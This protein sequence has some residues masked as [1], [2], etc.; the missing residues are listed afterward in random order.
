MAQTQS[1]AEELGHPFER[2][3][4]GALILLRIRWRM[5]QT[6]STETLQFAQERA[7]RAEELYAIYTSVGGKRPRKESLIE[8][9]AKL[10]EDFYALM[11]EQ[12]LRSTRSIFGSDAVDFALEAMKKEYPAS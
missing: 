11:W 5:V 3:C 4:K 8:G 1:M 10:D 7:K 9:L 12:G 2:R 6:L